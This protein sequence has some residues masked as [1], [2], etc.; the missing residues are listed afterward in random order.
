MSLFKHKF[1]SAKQSW[2]TPRDLFDRLNKEFNFN[3]DLAANEEN[4]KCNNF[5]DKE[6]DSM[7]QEWK[8]TCWLNPPYGEKAGYKLSQW[9]IK[10]YKESKKY[11]STIVMLIP[12][13]TNT[14]WWHDY[15]M[16]AYEVRLICGRP[17]FG[18]A[19]HGL[20]QPLAIVVFKPTK[21][22]TKFSSLYLKCK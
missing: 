5:Y 17:K 1:E 16:Q 7:T 21:E 4:K 11:N 22:P 13:R 18:D 9:V 8:G 15:V 14:R 10:A 12:A 2:E 3:L 6:K 20:P 19:T